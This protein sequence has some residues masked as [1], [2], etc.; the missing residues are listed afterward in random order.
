ML[1]GTEVP[2]IGDRMKEFIGKKVEF[3]LE[4]IGSFQARVV[5]DDKSFVYIKGEKDEFARRIVKSKIVSFMP[6]EQTNN[7]V[8]LQVLHCINPSIGCAGVQYVKEGNSFTQKDLAIFMSGCPA[9]CGTCRTG[10]LGD[11][12][13]VD[14]GKL[15][16]MMNG[17][18]FGDY[19]EVT[20]GEA[21]G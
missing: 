20:Q 21:N 13:T 3:W 4:G 8:N 17:M 12:R 2:S 9:R 19:P 18:M 15:S 16:E 6:L 5:N 10:T 11:L 7:D 1:Q 14:G